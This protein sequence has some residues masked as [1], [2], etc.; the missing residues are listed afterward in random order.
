MENFLI[1]DKFYSEIDDLIEDILDWEGVDCIE[2][3]KEGYSIEAH[4]CKLEPMFKFDLN[5]VL[6]TLNEERYPEDNE[7]I[8][9]QIVNLLKENI[10]FDKIKQG[11]PELYYPIRNGK[12]VITKNDLS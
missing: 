8:E 5:H 1:D 4:Q 6:N 7:R 9:N 2:D 11:M 3:L 10:N 12:F